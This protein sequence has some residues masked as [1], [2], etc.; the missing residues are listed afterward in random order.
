MSGI[1]VRRVESDET[2]Q[3]RNV[4]TPEGRKQ[5][6]PRRASRITARD[7]PDEWREP[8]VVLLGPVAG[9]VDA[10]IAN[11]FRGS[12]IGVGVQGWLREIGPADEV[13]PIA[14][15]QWDS[16]LL[17][18]VADALF[19]SEKD[20]PAEDVQRTVADWSR[21]V[22]I[23]ALTRGDGGAEVW[24]RGERRHIGAFPA[25]AIDATGA[26][27]IFASAFLIRYHE[28]SDPWDAARFAS[29]AASCV[30]EAEG[31]VDVPNRQRIEE[32]LLSHP[33]IA[34]CLV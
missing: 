19:V 8:S 24:H 28:T 30:I 3:I 9:E 15:D 31:V 32:R 4:Y 16:G 27:D 1:D 18:A 20:L 2:T 34:A 5:W 21:K 22:P 14:P 13:S 10:D 12:L 17:L 33:D 26:G 11:A 7:L 23:V 6:V 25:N 29:A